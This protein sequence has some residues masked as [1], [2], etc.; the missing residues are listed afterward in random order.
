[1]VVPVKAVSKKASG[2]AILFG[3]SVLLGKRCEKCYITGE[4]VSYP[5]Y[6]SIFGGI[7]EKDEEPSIAASRELYEETEISIPP[8]NLTFLKKI[9]NSDCSFYFHYY[10]SEEI[11]FPKLNPEHTQH[12]W[13]KLNYLKSFTENIDPQIIDCILSI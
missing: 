8:T 11:L 10:K 3:D 2:V 12:G 6:W 4:P 13:F 5:G 9:N 1:M 7:I